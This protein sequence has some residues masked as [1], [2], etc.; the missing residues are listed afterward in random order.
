MAIHIMD[1]GAELFQNNP[2]SVTMSSSVPVT[3]YLERKAIR[4]IF[5]VLRTIFRTLIWIE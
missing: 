2:M 4:C 3:V 1:A 5:P